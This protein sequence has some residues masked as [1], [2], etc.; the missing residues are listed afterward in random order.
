MRKNVIALMLV[1]PLLFIFVV[2]SSG[3]VASLGVSVSASGI[4][5]LEKPEHD[6]LRLDLASYNNDTRLSAEVRPANASNKEYSFRVEEVEGSEFADVSVKEDGTLIAK[7][8]GSARVVAVSKDGGYTDSLTVIVGSSKPYDFDFTLFS[9]GDADREN[10]LTSSESGYTAQAFSGRFGFQTTIVPSGFAG[11]KIQV[12]SGFAEIDE[13]AATILLP[14]SG[15]TVLSVTVEGGLGGDLRKTVTLDVS[16][17]ATVS[18]FTVNGGTGQVLSLEKESEQAS[19]Y[20]ESDSEPT[21]AEN[22][23]VAESEVTMLSAGRYRVDVRFAET[24]DSEFT[25]S[26]SAG[27][28]IEEVGISFEDFAFSLRSELPVQ[29]GNGA[30]VLL[31]TPVAFYAVPSV[32]V[33][34]ITYRWSVTNTA[35]SAQIELSQ[36]DSGSV[37]T[38]TARVGTAFTLQ[39][40]AYR[41]NKPMDIYPAELEIEAV[42]SV[43]AVQFT[44]KSSVGLAGRTTIAGERYD[45]TGDKTVSNI[46]E[47]KVLA[48][49]VDEAV[50]G[51]SDLDFTV[52][53][54]RV[55]KLSVTDERVTLIPVGTGE[56]TVAASWQGNDSFGKNVRATVTFNVAHRAVQVQTSAQLFKET[57]AGKAVVLGG[58]IKLGTNAAG[59]VLP[60][61]E[62]ES[63]LGKMKSTYNIEFYK[64]TNAEENAYVKYVLEFKNDVYGNGYSIDAEYFTNARDG[65][66]QPLLFRGPLYFVSYGQVASVAG[67]DNAAFLIR[68]DGVTLYNVTLL[69]CSDESLQT[70]GG[71][72]D[73]SNLNNVGT[74]LE[75]NADAQILNCRIRN[76]RNVVRAYG[77]NRDGSKYFIDSLSENK[78]AENERIDV[79]IEG[80]VISQGREFLLKIGANRALRAS[81]ALSSDVAACIEPNLLDENGN[82]YRAQSNQYLDDEY[83]Y[84][85]YVMTDVVLKDSVL[86]TSGLFTVGVESNFSGTVLYKDSADQGLNFEGWSGSGGTSFASVLRL[87]GDVRLYDWKDLSLVDSSTLI[88]TE[89]S[90]LKLNIG[91]ML[92]FV[93]SKDPARYGNLIQIV[94]GKQYVH[95]GIAY[96]GGGKNYAQ[97]SLASQIASLSDYSCYYVNIDVLKDAEGD[98]GHQGQ[99]LPLA[100]GTQDFRFYMYGS[101][102]ANN[103]QKQQ[104]D[105]AAG[106][107]YAG[108]KAVP[109]F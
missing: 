63:M 16:K 38:L 50:D 87:E 25:V 100:A 91:A 53:D 83:F 55:A 57:K 42:R 4:E 54:E 86:E 7:S 29:S 62:R 10:I 66:G 33:S 31:D 9:F 8:A 48:Y 58:N 67:Q 92:D 108:V 95:G 34:G 52:S 39:A 19:F 75:I 21:V 12:L 6:T 107:K 56:V 71:G 27:G 64:N 11:A 74:T 26:V 85:T 18:G 1:L 106:I 5:I 98:V 49:N 84:K 80:C 43:T 90:D 78:G 60:L 44:D 36:N 105:T 14:F 41:N 88:D 37:C 47:L 22:A 81:K 40:Q 13:G 102:S 73:L 69:G 72:Y 89:M 70:E 94:D 96:Y 23:N 28:K 45:G 101:D 109:L 99:I 17:T 59:E 76:G 15:R 46:Y 79:R 32:I 24:H 30:T 3:N 93:C 61:S 2:F 35:D 97:L 65:T 20:V 77:G 51:L 68:T 82:A 103:Y 104:S